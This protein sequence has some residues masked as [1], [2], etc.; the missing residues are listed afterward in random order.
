MLRRKGGWERKKE[1]IGWKEVAEIREQ[2]KLSA[3]GRRDIKIFN[4]KKK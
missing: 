4:R 1:A 2:E 3:K